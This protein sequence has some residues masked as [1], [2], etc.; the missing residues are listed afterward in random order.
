VLAITGL[1]TSA[2]LWPVQQTFDYDPDR[3]IPVL[4]DNFDP[5]PDPPIRC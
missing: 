2:R 3:F 1:D 5:S 4:S